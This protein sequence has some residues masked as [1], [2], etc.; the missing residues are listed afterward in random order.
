MIL[1]KCSTFFS[2]GQ[3]HS[4]KTYADHK[5]TYRSPIDGR[6]M[7]GAL[8][9][10]NATW[11]RPTLMYTGKD[12]LARKGYILEVDGTKTFGAWKENS[13][14]DSLVGLQQPSAF[15]PIP[16][17]SLLDER[18]TYNEIEENTESDIDLFVGIMCR[19][20]PL[21]RVASNNTSSSQF[22]KYIQPLRYEPA[23][24]VFNP[25]SDK[26]SCYYNEIDNQHLPRGVLGIQKCKF[27]TPFAVSFPHF[28]HADKW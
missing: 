10:K 14:C 11:E 21:K 3:T 27:G 16:L 1:I 28:L 6:C 18:P 17:T 24:Y 25:T 4:S 19:S 22:T 20:I 8:R 26:E 12:D 9:D 23:E 7:F 2:S 5:V 13:K 15:P